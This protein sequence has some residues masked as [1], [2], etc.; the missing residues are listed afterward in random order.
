[1]MTDYLARL[2]QLDGT[3]ALDEL[4][5]SPAFKV[6][7]REPAEYSQGFIEGSV[8]IPLRTLTRQLDVLPGLDQP[9]VVICGSNHRAAIAQATLQILGYKDV[10]SLDGGVAAWLKAKLPLVK[11]PVPALTRGTAPEVDA[12]YLAVLDEY[13]RQTLPEDYGMASPKEM[14]KAVAEAFLG[15]APTLID[16]RA[17]DLFAGGNI[18]GSVNIELTGLLDRLDEIPFTQDFSD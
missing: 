3:I 14:A 2:P 18:S 17:P 11:D 8:N 13:L 7:V 9:I 5:A 12:E 10:R 6:D 4:A 15:L 1:M 16:V